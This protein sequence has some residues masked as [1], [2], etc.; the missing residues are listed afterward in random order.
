M[1]IRWKSLIATMGV[2]A[3]PPLAA[4]SSPAY[5]DGCVKAFMDSIT[6]QKGAI[7]LRESRYVDTGLP[8]GSSDLTMTARDAHDNHTVARA[9][10]SI[11]VN[12]EVTLHAE[13]IGGL[14]AF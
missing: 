2:L 5:L 14:E 7:K 9:V 11:G 12:G 6:S 8:L 4:A 10:C 13:P 3:L 1:N